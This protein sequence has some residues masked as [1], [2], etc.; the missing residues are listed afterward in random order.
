MEDMYHIPVNSVLAPVKSESIDNM[1]VVPPSFS[2]VSQPLS[3]GT[4]TILCSN[5]TL[6]VALFAG[7]ASGSVSADGVLWT[8]ISLPVTGTWISMAYG[9]GIFLAIDSG[10]NNLITSPDGVNWTVGQTPLTIG[11]AVAFGNG[12][13]A[14]VQANY[15][16]MCTTADGVNFTTGNL[17]SA[18]SWGYIAY[19]GVSGVWMVIAPN[20]TSSATSTNGLT[21]TALAM[22]TSDSWAGLA[23]N[24]TG[25]VT[26]TYDASGVVNSSAN[27]T[28]WVAEAWDADYYQAIGYGNGVYMGVASNS[29]DV[30]TSANGT[31]FTYATPL[32]GLNACAVCYHTASASWVVAQSASAILYLSPDN[33]NT[34]SSASFAIPYSCG[35]YGNGTYVALCSAGSTSYVSAT[36]FTWR[37]VPLPLSGV[38]WFSVTWG[39]DKFVALPATGNQA[40][41]SYNGV[42]WYP[43][44]LPVSLTAGA[45][46]VF[47]N[48]QW[49]AVGATVAQG[50]Y[51]VDGV[52]WVAVA[53]TVTDPGSITFGNNLFVSVFSG[54]SI[55]S[56]TAS[57]NLPTP[58]AGAMSSSTTWS[59]VA[60]GRGVFVA[61]N[62]TTSCA[63]SSNGLN[64]KAVTLPVNV[65]PLA[66]VFAFGN[67]LAFG[68]ASNQALASPDGLTWRAFTLPI[69]GAHVCGVLVGKNNVVV[70]GSDGSIMA[71]NDINGTHYGNFA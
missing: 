10:S 11:Q 51:S 1:N 6:V 42:Q 24:G 57:P 44:T 27:G 2:V 62:T 18:A 30:E 13:F 45:K 3:V 71:S 22:T 66:L 68:S 35:A 48:G 69:S 39:Y 14:I 4:S 25:F 52:R 70:I 49:L 7:T 21:W 37:A 56:A 20:S 63:V 50:M 34:W 54:T 12:H 23:S 64:W 33:G 53:A 58:R 5:G 36:G 8:S 41:Y 46:C 19:A 59:M 67:F 47:G 38:N 43:I 15:A 16:L 55:N 29:G 40:M 61:V 9:N 32:P 28:S 31:S 26:I 17:P 65:T 60:Y